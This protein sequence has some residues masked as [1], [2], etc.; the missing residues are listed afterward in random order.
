MTRESTGSTGTVDGAL[1]SAG[2]TG[3]K[4]G[5]SDTVRTL[6]A[7]GIAAYALVHLVIAWI[8]VQI[9]L[10]TG[11]GSA[12]QQGAL[13][14]L[15]DT[16]VGTPLLWVLAAGLV[17]LAGWQL[18]NAAVGYTEIGSTGKRAAH[19]AVAAARAV[20]YLALAFAAVRTAAGKTSNS[21][22]KSRG[23]TAHLMDGT[24]GR[25]LVALIGA[26]VAGVGVG[27]IVRGITK[28]FTDHL[29]DT[30]SETAVRLGQIGYVAKGIALIV[31]GGLFVWAAITYDPEKAGGL[32]AAL[33]TVARA[34]FGSVLLIVLAL[35][36]ACF[37]AY[38]L[39]WARHPR[40]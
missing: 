2:R 21:N 31:L 12:D 38:A 16:P 25:L 8:A 19:R 11:G 15:K 32:D 22:N 34:P 40:R 6:A 35:G 28:K 27:L 30:S 26:V 20:L 5:S 3:R 36:F 14:R 39:Y 18:L 9:A 13:A 17:A 24:G 33:R 4:A 10:G 29:D 37:G 1:R 7:V 23:F